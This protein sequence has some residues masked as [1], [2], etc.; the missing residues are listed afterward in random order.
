MIID[1]TRPWES[2]LIFA[3][4]LVHLDCPIQPLSLYSGALVFGL[5][6]EGRRR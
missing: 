5:V 2:P 6:Q 4:F 1:L 3:E